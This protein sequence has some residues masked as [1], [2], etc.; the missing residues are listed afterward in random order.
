MK[1]T[2]SIKMLAG[3]GFLFLN[4]SVFA[5]EAKP[6]QLGDFQAWTV[7]DASLEY[8]DNP[9]RQIDDEDSSTVFRATPSIKLTNNSA[10]R[11]IAFN[12]EAELVR[13][14]DS[15]EDNYLSHNLGADFLFKASPL[16]SFGI[17]ANYI[18][19]NE[20][21]GTGS[22]EGS[23]AEGEGA[24]EFTEVKGDLTYYYGAENNPFSGEFSISA[25]DI[26]FDNF[27][28][29]TEQRDR[30]YTGLEVLLDYKFSVAT[31]VFLD[32][33][34]KDNS[35]SSPVSDGIQ[36]D[37]DEITTHLGLAWSA[38]RNTTGRVGVGRTSKD[39]AEAGD[40]STF[41]TWDAAIDWEPAQQD[42]VSLRANKYISEAA[43]TGL[44][45]VST[46][47]DLSWSHNISPA[48]SFS[49]FG[50]VRDAEF[51]NEVREDDTTSYGLKALYK[52]NRQMDLAISYENEDKD[53]NLNE[54]DYDR[55]VIA[56][57]LSIG[58]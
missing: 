45:V 23:L 16:N 44:F 4:Y 5:A 57:T 30:S 6:V 56:A 18:D 27:R 2:N 50:S 21:R 53:S 47:T 26:E 37:N 28:E 48:W 15:S 11:D 10:S 35:Y 55:N 17:N 7:L 39:V 34:Y 42:K 41:T 49:L 9:F 24:T 20:V 36:L 14:L 32:V 52:F 40:D 3:L 43:G 31:S 22:S 1:K 8:D 51:E 33:I 12:Y 58:L 13:F 46:A 25:G 54:F 19:G 29:S 38:T